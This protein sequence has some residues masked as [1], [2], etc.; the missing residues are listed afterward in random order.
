MSNDILE[1]PAI[2]DGDAV[3]QI[4]YGLNMSEVLD[5][6]VT[7]MDHYKNPLTGEELE[8]KYGH[9]S[10]SMK[11][12]NVGNAIRSTIRNAGFD[13]K[14]VSYSTLTGIVIKSL[15]GRIDSLEGFSGEVE[16]AGEFYNSRFEDIEFRL[17]KAEQRLKA[18]DGLS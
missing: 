4:L 8:E 9:L 2:E 16:E 18:L 11:R 7:L 17:D 13:P 3:S 5:I 1:Q 15:K 12:Q 10:D 14:V 6:A